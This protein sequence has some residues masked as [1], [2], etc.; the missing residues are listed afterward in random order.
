MVVMAASGGMLPRPM[1]PR[2]V[3]V[4]QRSK[5]VESEPEPACLSTTRGP[6]KRTRKMRIQEAHDAPV[7]RD[8]GASILQ[9][10]PVEE[11]PMLS[12]PRDW[13]PTATKASPVA[14]HSHGRLCLVESEPE[15][16]EGLRITLAAPG[17]QAKTVIATMRPLGMVF[18]KVPPFRVN[19]V[20]PAGH[21]ED[22]GIQVGWEVKQ[23][24]TV[25]LRWLTL[26]EAE[27]DLAAAR[28]AIA[29]LPVR[30]QMVV[31]APG[32]DR[33]TVV[34]T[35]APVGMEFNPWPPF[36]VTRV[37]AFSHAENLGV[38]KD[39]LVR[40]VGGVELT[41]WSDVRLALAQ[42]KLLPSFYS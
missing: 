6:N 40:R 18:Q 34:L 7:A 38:Q 36:D 33:Q 41:D 17:G 24:G 28:Q 29:S 15:L 25:A 12:V 5:T 13:K 3:C 1:W 20:E 11:P 23:V 4:P 9:L 37:T 21:V 14:R 30:L 31:Q 26:V 2:D 39:W 10:E 42:F 22:L 19:T 16:S 32:G 35:A 27:A 8:L